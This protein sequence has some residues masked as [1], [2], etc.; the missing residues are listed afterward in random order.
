[1]PLVALILA[2]TVLL[3]G[4]VVTAGVMVV[5]AVADR[6]KEA[7]KPITEPTLPQIPTPD[8]P[9]PPTDLPT[10]PTDLPALPG[11]T[12]RTITVTYQVTGD[13]PAQIGYVDKPGE[14]PK[15]ITNAKL[16]WKVTTTMQSPTL[17]LVTAIRGNTESGSISCRATVDGEEVAHSDRDGGFATVSCSKFVLE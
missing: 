14:M 13:G 6:A 10:R 1:V 2:V 3:C 4:G 9:G 7:V 16:P 15:R 12:G 11:T 17:V 8:L 5:D